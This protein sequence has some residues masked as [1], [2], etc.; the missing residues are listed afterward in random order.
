MVNINENKLSHLFQQAKVEPVHTSFDETKLSFLNSIQSSAVVRKKNLF[1]LKNGIML[2]LVSA[3]IITAIIQVNQP[4]EK[5][6]KETTVIEQ[7]EQKEKIESHPE[8]IEPIKNKVKKEQKKVEISN[9]KA[10]SGLIPTQSTENKIYQKEYLEKQE[11]P[12]AYRFPSLTEKEKIENAKRKRKMMKNLVKFNKKEYAFIPSGSLNTSQGKKSI[13]SFH[14][15]TTEVSN[16]QYKTFLMDL[17]EKGEMEKFRL[18]SPQLDVWPNNSDGSSNPLNESYF[19][20]PAYDDYPVVGVSPKGVELYC[21][22]LSKEVIPYYPKSRYPDTWIKVRIPTD[23][24]WMYVANEGNSEIK[25]QWSSEG[26]QNEDG[27]Y[28]ANYNTETMSDGAVYTAKTR[29][30][31]PNSFGVYNLFGNVAEIVYYVNNHYSIGTKG[32][33]WQSQINELDI[34]YEEVKAENFQPSANIGFRVVIS[35]VKK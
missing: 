21:E 32:G 35:F 13:Q 34:D 18:A 29:T 6:K 3:V 8:P 27:C 17:V 33:G 15:Q 7:V 11:V 26:L 19:S 31:N 22:W 23:I 5:E 14:V 16:L 4:V 24:E 28:L 20:H 25:H 12:I 10:H 9:D 30:Y 1:N 2:S